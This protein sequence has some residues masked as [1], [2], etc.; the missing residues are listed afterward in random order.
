MTTFE[1][2]PVSSARTLCRSRSDGPVAGV[3]AAMAR[4]TDTDPTLWRVLAVVLS[5]V[6]GAGVLLYA[7]GWFL[8]PVEGRCGSPADR[9]LHRHG[10]LLRNRNALLVVAALVALY[11]AARDSQAVWVLSVLAAVGY[12]AY[13]ERQGSVP[14]PAPAPAPAGPVPALADPPP[15]RRP[16]LG[17]RSRSRLGRVTVSAALLVVGVLSLLAQ[18]GDSA[19]TPARTLAA[20]L[21][22]VGTGLVVGAWYGRSRLLV[23]LGLVMALALGPLAVLQDVPGGGFGARNWSPAGAGSTFSLTAG[24]AELDLTALPAVG[25]GAIRASVGV[26]RLVV[27]VPPGSAVEIRAHLGAGAL[28]VDGRSRSGNDLSADIPSPTGTSAPV[29]VTARLSAGR[30]EV[31]YA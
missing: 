2:P 4:W 14:A 17:P 13:R 15:R 31:R 10:H 21:L 8:I 16:I 6:G 12:L 30:L 20:A 27:T 29:V 19:V 5:F 28:V 9:V 1:A 23:L 3:C 26:G 11:A 22:V 25:P 7:A 24:D 18:Q